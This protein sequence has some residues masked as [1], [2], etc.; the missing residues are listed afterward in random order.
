VFLAILHDFYVNDLLIEAS[1]ID[2]AA[3]LARQ[4]NEVLRKGCFP[5]RKWL[6]N[7]SSI[8]RQFD[9]N[10]KQDI[11]PIVKDDCRKTGFIWQSSSDK[12]GFS[13]E[14]KLRRV[15]K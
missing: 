1:S 14:T 9:K 7:E 13:V 12:L 10:S 6:S 15:T 3:I 4:I 11:I 5:L 2:E 8:T